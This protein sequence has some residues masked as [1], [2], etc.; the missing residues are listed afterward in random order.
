MNVDLK[1]A[2]LTSTYIDL[3]NRNRDKIFCL[4]S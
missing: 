4:E 1:V 3:F 2:D